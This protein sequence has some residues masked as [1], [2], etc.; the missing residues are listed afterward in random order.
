M[1]TLVTGSDGYNGFAASRRRVTDIGVGIAGG[2]NNGA[3]GISC[4]CNGADQ[5]AEIPS[6]AGAVNA[7]AQVNHVGLIPISR[8]AIDR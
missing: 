8:H 5:A 7:Q 2:D 3:T 6:S 1:P 4:L